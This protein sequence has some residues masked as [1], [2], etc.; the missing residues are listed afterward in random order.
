MRNSCWFAHFWRISENSFWEEQSDFNWYHNG[1]FNDFNK[2]L[3]NIISLFEYWEEST[4][5]ENAFYE[6]QIIITFWLLISILI[7]FIYTI[8]W[9]GNMKPC[10][11][12]ARRNEVSN[13]I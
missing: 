4:Q 2:R 6:D 9:N 3:Q 7:L 10:R 8:S 5:F 11:F 1:Q 13:N 12:L